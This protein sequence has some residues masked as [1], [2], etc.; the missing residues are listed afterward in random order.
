M[1]RAPVSIVVTADVSGELEACGRR[2]HPLGGAARRVGAISQMRGATLVVDGG[3]HFFG[4]APM[5][6]AGRA[7]ALARAEVLADALAMTRAAAMA[8]G[9]R[10]L[11][12]GRD[13]L[14]K[15]ADR[16]GLALVSCN[17]VDMQSNLPAYP[18]GILID[19]GGTRIAVIGVAADAP[20]YAAAGLTVTPAKPA[21]QTALAKSKA[22]G[23]HQVVGLFHGTPDQFADVSLAGFSL[24]IWSATTSSAAATTAV[25]TGAGSRGQ[26]LL[27]DRA[28]RRQMSWLD[29]SVTANPV[30]QAKAAAVAIQHAVAPTERTYS[31]TGHCK[32]CHVEAFRQWKATRHAKSWRT[33]VHARQTSNMDCL[34]CHVTGFDRPGGPQRTVGLTRF[35]NVGCEACHGPS[36]AHVRTPTVAVGPVDTAR[37]CFEC[38]RDQADQKPFDL[39]AR[40]DAIVDERHGRR[41]PIR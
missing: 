37:V 5:T 41:A 15:L 22:D 33:L 29:R 31:G 20:G 16:A 23:A 3:D 21:I 25:A 30:V 19:R 32:K 18:P 14:A 36:R 13:V 4:V 34:P 17:L 40:L 35:I 8:V 39:D 10:D 6:P 2:A 12:L 26:G 9:D 7:E 38:H 24:V 1:P 27:V 11:A 28:G